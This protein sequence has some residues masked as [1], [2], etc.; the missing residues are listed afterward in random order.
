VHARDL[1]VSIEPP[2]RGESGELARPDDGD[3]G[4]DVVAL[5]ERR[6]TDPNARDVSDRVQLPRVEVADLDPD[7]SRSHGSRA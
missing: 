1:A 2:E 6:M 4:A 7:V 3:A 5:D